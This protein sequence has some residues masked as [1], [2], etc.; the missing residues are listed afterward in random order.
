MVTDEIVNA[1][2]TMIDRCEDKERKRGMEMMRDMLLDFDG[3][4]WNKEPDTEAFDWID[5]YLKTREFLVEFKETS[6][7]RLYIEARNEQEALREAEKLWNDGDV[8]IADDSFVDI[9]YSIVEEG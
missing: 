2:D 6:A 9:E 1:M 3:E 4:K 7:K 8:I 5:K